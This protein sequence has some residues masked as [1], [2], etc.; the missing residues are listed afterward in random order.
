MD[1]PQPSQS[2]CW[3]VWLEKH[4]A[5]ALATFGLSAVATAA[6]HVPTRNMTSIHAHLHQIQPAF[7]QRESLGN[8]FKKATRYVIALHWLELQRRTAERWRRPD[9]K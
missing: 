2:G 3:P 1:E 7:I 4:E 5:Q 8:L 6:P 9:S